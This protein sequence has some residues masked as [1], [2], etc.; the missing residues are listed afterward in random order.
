MSIDT[1]PSIISLSLNRLSVADSSDTDITSQSSIS[2][3]DQIIKHETGGLSINNHPS[4]LPWIIH[5]FFECQLSCELPL[6]IM[7][8]FNSGKLK[9]ASMFVS[10]LTSTNEGQKLPTLSQAHEWW[11]YGAQGKLIIQFLS[12]Q[13]KITPSLENTSIE[14]LKNPACGPKESINP[15]H[16]LRDRFM[17]QGNDL[18]LDIDFADVPEGQQQIKGLPPYFVQNLC[19]KTIF[20]ERY[21]GANFS[22][23]LQ[24]LDYIRDLEATRRD[25][26]REAAQRLGITKEDWREVLH[27]DPDAKQWII[28]MQALEI[29]IAA[30]Y[31]AIFVDLRVWV[32]RSTRY[33][34]PL[35][36]HTIDDD[37]RAPVFPILQAKRPCDA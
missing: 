14:D 21:E 11:H 25:S 27:E 23:A 9:H 10:R 18:L 15:D 32:R 7:F 13:Q 12:S 33:R 37:Q 3:V 1:S 30:Y 8:A 36:D 34:P 5:Q 31:A 19:L 16:D 24:G 22:L 17:D 4:G 28:N 2:T 20:A 29:D 26:L 35:T 6:R